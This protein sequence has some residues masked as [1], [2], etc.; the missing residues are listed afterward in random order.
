MGTDLDPYCSSN[1][2]PSHHGGE[3]EITIKKKYTEY[4]NKSQI[5]N[6]VS[7]ENQN[8]PHKIIIILKAASKCVSLRSQM[9]SL[10]PLRDGCS[11]S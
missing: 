1:T 8:K 2:L 5:K 10:K 11:F 9:E 4:E 6:L 7:K 3:N